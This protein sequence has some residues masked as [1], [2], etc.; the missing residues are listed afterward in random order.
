MQPTTYFQAAGF[1]CYNENI[2]V[3]KLHNTYVT[4]YVHDNFLKSYQ[5]TADSFYRAIDSNGS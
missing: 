5:V 1:L 4:L 3:L 2:I